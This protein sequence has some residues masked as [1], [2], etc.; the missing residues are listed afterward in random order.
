[1]FQLL[2]YPLPLIY[3]DKGDIVPIKDYFEIQLKTQN[4]KNFN[5]VSKAKS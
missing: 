3:S 4:Y 2:N 5:I 1:V